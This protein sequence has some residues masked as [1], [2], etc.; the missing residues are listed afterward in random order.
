MGLIIFFGSAALVLLISTI[1]LSVV[2]VHHFKQSRYY[3]SLKKR[4]KE[5]AET[6]N[7]AP[8]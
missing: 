4:D 5:S 8:L 1:Y 3:K 2:F 6:V 7:G